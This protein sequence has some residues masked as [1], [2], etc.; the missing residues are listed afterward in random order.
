MW[1][2]EDER[3][4]FEKEEKDLIITIKAKKERISFHGKNNDKL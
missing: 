2:M 4:V 3:A 1:R